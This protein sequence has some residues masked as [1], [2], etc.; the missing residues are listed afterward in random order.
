M[1]KPLLSA[2]VSA[3]FRRCFKIVLTVPGY[4]PTEVVIKQCVRA[5]AC[6]CRLS[7]SLY[8]C[9]KCVYSCVLINEY[10]EYFWKKQKVFFKF[11]KLFWF[12]SVKCVY[13]CVLI[14]EYFE[15]FWKKQKVFLSFESYFGFESHCLIVAG[16]RSCTCFHSAKSIKAREIGAF[17][18]SSKQATKQVEEPQARK[19]KWKTAFQ[20]LFFFYE[21]FFL[22]IFY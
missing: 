8:S 12:R 10:F 15:Y 21:F 19:K 13:S 1:R 7:L 20:R 9:V 2:R 11:R 17:R 22:I 6:K 16:S 18:T 3:L 5:R 14:N 4:S